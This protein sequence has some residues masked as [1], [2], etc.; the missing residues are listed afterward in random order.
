MFLFCKQILDMSDIEQVNSL[1]REYGLFDSLQYRDRPLGGYWKKVTYK[2]PGIIRGCWTQM[3]DEE[4]ETVYLH[5][6]CSSFHKL[7]IDDLLFFIERDIRE[8]TGLE[9]REVLK[10][11][12]RK[13]KKENRRLLEE[14]VASKEE[15]VLLLEQNMSLRK[16]LELSGI[17][18]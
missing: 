9:K 16:I 7:N 18:I 10:K 15:V 12:L 13:A 1:F 5:P 17:D 8:K 3:T 4:G 2:V 11:K 6:R 14:C